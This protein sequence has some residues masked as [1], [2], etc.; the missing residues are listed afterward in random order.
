M[1]EA[2]DRVR[3][4]RELPLFPLPIALFPGVPLPLHI[5]EPRYREMLKD[6][7]A[8]NNF[9]GISYFDAGESDA[10][11]PP[12]GHVGCVAEIVEVQDQPDGRANIITVG[13]IRYHIDEYIERGDSYLVGRPTFFEDEAEDDTELNE[14]AREVTDLF[15]RIA[16]AMRSLNNERA[17]L[18]DLPEADPE[19]LSFLIAAAL[20]IDSEIKLDLLEMRSTIR[21]L[22]RIRDMLKEAASGYEERARVHLVAKTNGHSG[23][24]FPIG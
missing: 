2:F 6:A 7:R 20:E 23:K 8:G 1:T 13:I 19:R 16:R 5:F 12:A 22:T 18:P 21:R 15:M 17:T 11:T 10:Q 24:N 4:V 14:R 3:G 9:I